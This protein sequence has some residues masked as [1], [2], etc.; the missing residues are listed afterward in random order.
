MVVKWKINQGFD[1]NSHV[2]S[3]SPYIH[4][5]QHTSVTYH[6]GKRKITEKWKWWNVCGLKNW[7]IG[8]QLIWWTTFN[9]KVLIISWSF[10]VS[11]FFAQNEKK[12]RL[13]CTMTS[14]PIGRAAKVPWSQTQDKSMKRLMSC[15]VTSSC[16]EFKHSRCHFFLQAFIHSSIHPAVLALHTWPLLGTG[17]ARLHVISS[18]KTPCWS[19]W[20][21][22][23]FKQSFRSESRKL[24]IDECDD[25]D[26]VSRAALQVHWCL[27]G[28]FI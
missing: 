11:L 4:H 2:L 23:G 13:T 10:I 9:L 25:E 17:A 12:N 3:F 26:A 18:Q 16:G 24:R 5:S 1:E 7:M 6:W 21:E 20:G 27:T 28:E 22:N 15:S 8:C 19:V 14:P